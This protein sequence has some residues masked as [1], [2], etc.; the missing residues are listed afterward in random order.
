MSGIRKT[1]WEGMWENG[2]RLGDTRSEEGTAVQDCA[3]SCSLSLQ[4]APISRRIKSLRSKFCPILVV[5]VLALVASYCSTCNVWHLPLCFVVQCVTLY[6]AVN[7]VLS[8]ETF[9]ECRRAGP[10]LFVYGKCPAYW[11]LFSFC[12]QVSFCLAIRPFTAFQLKSEPP[13]FCVGMLSTNGRF[14][15]RLCRATVRTMKMET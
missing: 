13:N 5:P 14:A 1:F 2:D 4:R 15:R 12:T 6:S 10:P 11:P 8:I 3:H 9:R 7:H